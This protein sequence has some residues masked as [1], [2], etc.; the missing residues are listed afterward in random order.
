MGVVENNDVRPVLE[1][2][3]IL[4]VLGLG[5]CFSFELPSWNSLPPMRKSEVGRD[6]FSG[7]V[8]SMLVLLSR[9]LRKL[10]SDSAGLPLDPIVVRLLG[11]SMVHGIRYKVHG[12]KV[13]IRECGVIVAGV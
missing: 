2:D 5:T 10:N 13:R 6:V 4:S 12:I 3:R 8:D 7:G 1:S 11:V 9:L